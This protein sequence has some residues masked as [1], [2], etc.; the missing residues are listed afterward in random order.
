[1]QAAAQM[2]LQ[3]HVLAPER[4][5]QQRLHCAR[6]RSRHVAHSLVPNATNKL[7]RLRSRIPNKKFSEFHLVRA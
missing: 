4:L 1:M 2:R 3:I 7:A 5:G 6:I